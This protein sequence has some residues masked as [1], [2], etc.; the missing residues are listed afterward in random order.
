VN[1]LTGS[2]RVVDDLGE[3]PPLDFRWNEEAIVAALYELHDLAG[4]RRKPRAAGP[5]GVGGEEV[6]RWEIATRLLQRLTL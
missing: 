3:A 2:D 6:R 4:Y 5:R 1:A